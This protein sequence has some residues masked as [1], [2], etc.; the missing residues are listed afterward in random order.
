MLSNVLETRT[1]FF[2]IRRRRQCYNGHRFTTLEVVATVE[3]TPTFPAQR[4][5]VRA[6]A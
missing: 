1:H 2:E 3:A 4:K 5:L 6:P